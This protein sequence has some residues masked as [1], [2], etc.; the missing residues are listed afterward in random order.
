MTHSCSIANHTLWRALLGARCDK[1]LTPQSS[2]ENLRVEA[3]LVF[4][5]L[6]GVA[7]GTDVGGVDVHHR[8]LPGFVQ[9]GLLL[10]EQ[11]AGEQG[12]QGNTREQRGAMD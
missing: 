6:R 8:D 1:G 3:L 11:L 9:L 10:P 2:T 5:D 7:V 12:L 4:P